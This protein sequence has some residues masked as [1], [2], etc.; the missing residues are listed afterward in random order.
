M[1]RANHIIGLPVVTAT[2]SREIATIRDVAYTSSMDQVTGFLL[3]GADRDALP[4]DSV[5]K[6]SADTV[7]IRG[8]SALVDHDDVPNIK[9]AVDSSTSLNDLSLFDRDGD[10]IGSIED[11]FLDESTGRVV[12]FQVHVD[13]LPDAVRGSYIRRPSEQ[14]DMSRREEDVP[15]DTDADPGRVGTGYDYTTTDEGEY[16]P[17]GRG[18]DESEVKFFLPIDRITAWDDDGARID[19]DRDRDDLFRRQFP[20]G[21]DEGRDYP[22]RRAA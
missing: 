16:S 14:P 10:K 20:E 3:D 6:I 7:I 13:D 22:R 21:Y 2:D 9:R 12:G 5:Q 17:V 4:F 19:Y 18:D 8:E 15:Y 1:R 11:T